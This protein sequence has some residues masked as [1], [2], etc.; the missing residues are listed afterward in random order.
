M[1]NLN[2]MTE[3]NDQNAECH[4]MVSHYVMNSQAI[5]MVGPFVHKYGKKSTDGCMNQGG[6]PQRRLA[7]RVTM[8]RALWTAYNIAYGVPS[9]GQ[10][11]TGGCHGL[12]CTGMNSARGGHTVKFLTRS[13][14]M[15]HSQH[16]QVA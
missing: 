2:D 1:P 4:C 8:A 10:C 14:M 3:C 9:V 11:G 5:A 6:D 15:H 16:R 12:A 7:V 13:I